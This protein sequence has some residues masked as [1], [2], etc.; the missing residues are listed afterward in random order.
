M[1]RVAANSEHITPP[2]LERARR[3][4]LHSLQHDLAYRSIKV[5]G[6]GSPTTGVLLGHVNKMLFPSSLYGRLISLRT[7]V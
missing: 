3:L 1:P 4:A 2:A 5:A 6:P 7:K